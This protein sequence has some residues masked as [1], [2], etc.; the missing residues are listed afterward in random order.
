[1]IYRELERAGRQSIQYFYEYLMTAMAETM[2]LG[3]PYVVGFKVV[4]VDQGILRRPAD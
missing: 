3:C 1:M 4:V 2:S